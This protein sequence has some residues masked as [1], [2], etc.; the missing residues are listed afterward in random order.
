[1]EFTGE[2]FV[3]EICGEIAAEHYHRYYLASTL[4]AGKDVLDIA[5]GEGYGSSILARSAAKVTGVDI[6]PDAVSNAQKKY[7]LDNITFLQGSAT[8]IPVPDS[9]M[10]VVVSFE[11]LEHLQDQETMLR[12]IC[13]V[14]RANGLLIMSTPNKQ[15]YKRDDDPFH[16]KE[17][18]R[19]DFLSLLQ[20]HFSHVELFGQKVF[21]GSLLGGNATGETQLFRLNDDATQGEVLPF[22]EQCVYFIAF[23]SNADLPVIPNSFLDYPQEKSDRVTQLLQECNFLHNR[24]CAAE[25]S[26]KHAN[27]ILSTIFSSHSWRMTAPLRYLGKFLLPDFNKRKK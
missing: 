7:P 2:R 11:T 10:D 14:L 24:V 12:E 26:L 5:S 8:N 27:N 3:P 15:H 1:M 9:S 16:V 18:E 22:L 4:V 6:S 17:L 23:A 20:A 25:E 13:R 19:E 21:F